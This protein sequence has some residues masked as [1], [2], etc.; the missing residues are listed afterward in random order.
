MSAG[1][2]PLG[3]GQLIDLALFIEKR[4]DVLVLRALVAI[5]I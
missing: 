1:P 4:F 3:I 5:L 2:R